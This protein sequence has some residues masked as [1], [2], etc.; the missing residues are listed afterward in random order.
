LKL[1]SIHPRDLAQQL[2]LLHY[3]L[4]KDITPIAFVHHK[5]SEAVQKLTA[6]S[7]KT[8]YWVASE[9]A[10]YS[11]V[12]SRASVIKHFLRVGR[13]CMILNSF[14]TLMAIIGGLT[15]VPISRMKSAWGRIP[16]K[17]ITLLRD[18]QSLMDCGGNYKKYRTRLEV[19]P[20]PALPFLGIFQR[21]ITFLESCV[22]LNT[23][24][25]SSSSAYISSTLSD[26]SSFS[27]A[28]THPSTSV[29]LSAIESLSTSPF[30]SDCPGD[31]KSKLFGA[32]RFVEE[33]KL[34]EFEGLMHIARLVRGMQRFQAIGYKS[35]GIHDAPNIQA[36][37][38]ERMSHNLSDRALELAAVACE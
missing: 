1:S 17:Y 21:D 8:S 6:G 3:D 27:L 34:V 20:L 35:T 2:T 23:T 10:G 11:S 32:D 7:T 38:L 37:I 33:E 5:S 24:S 36:F 14:H 19:C 12:R 9:I 28:N 25:A 4:F 16:P 29:D 26:F 15:M 31:R 13:E 22:Y 18:M 30:L